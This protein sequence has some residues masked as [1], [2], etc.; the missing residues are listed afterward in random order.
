MG[1]HTRDEERG[2]EPVSA[3]YCGWRGKRASALCALLAA[4]L[5]HGD[6]CV[7]NWMRFA[8][9]E[10]IPSTVHVAARGPDGFVYLGGRD[11]LYRLEGGSLNAWYPEPGNQAA[12]P[13]G[14]V[15]ALH[16]DGEALWVGTGGGLLKFV[17]GS[18]RFEP[19]AHTVDEGASKRITALHQRGNRLFV[20]TAEGGSV[21]DVET[22]VFQAGMNTSSLEFT[23]AITRFV[24]FDGSVVAASS[25]GLL[26]IHPDGRTEAV[27]LSPGLPS[28]YRIADIALDTDGVLW[29][30]ATD[31]LYRVESLAASSAERL[32]REEQ[33]GLPEGV[34]VALGIDRQGNLWAG[35]REG[36]SRWA[37]GEAGFRHCRR[38]TSDSGEPALSVA[39]LDGTLGPS[40][41]L[42]SWGRGAFFAPPDRGTRR[43]VPGGEHQQGLPDQPIWSAIV[44]PDERLVLGTG[45]GVYRETG[46]LSDKFTA[47]APDQLGGLRVYALLRDNAG[48][49]WI[50]TSRGLFVAREDAVIAVTL[51]NPADTE[52]ATTPVF[53][54]QATGEEIAVATGHGLYLIDAE[55]HNLLHLFRARREVVVPSDTGLTDIDANRIWSVTVRGRSLYAASDTGAFHFDHPTRALVA[56]TS[57]WGDPARPRSGRIYAVVASADNRVFIATESGL[58]ETDPAFMSYRHVA[59]ANHVRFRAVMAARTS[60]DG[61]LWFAVAGNGMFRYRPAL[62]EW[63]HLSQIDGL[64]SN[65]VGQLGLHELADGRIAIA[66]G[67]SGMTLI[68]PARATSSEQTPFAL[69]AH[70]VTLG[71]DVATG[72]RVVIGP[73]RRD[74]SLHFAVPIL[75]GP[76]FQE[77]RYALWR[78]RLAPSEGRIRL[79]DELLLTQMQPGDYRF[80][81][82]LQSS[83]GRLSEPLVF[84]IS[85]RQYWWQS[86]YAHAGGFALGAAALLGVFAW[87]TRVIQQRYD[88]LHSE[89]QRIAQDLHDTFLQEML[90]ALMIGRSIDTTELQHAER[91]KTERV[92]EL[93]EDASR[94]ARSSVNE[95]VEHGAIVDLA[96]DLRECTLDSPFLKGATLHVSESGS[97]WRLPR[98]SCFFVYRAAREAINNA[99]KHARADSVR[100]TIDWKPWSMRLAVIDDGI[101]FDP[102]ANTDREGF[103]LHALRRL[104]RAAKAKVDIISAPGQGTRVEFALRRFPMF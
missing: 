69:S 44:T 39:T 4:G 35:S 7:P 80:E 79:G 26:Q 41:F 85:V 78:D 52:G 10:S 88:L 28:R 31:A 71:R 43:I 3:G 51:G 66:N 92:I 63:T 56:S 34:L 76:D 89:R 12:L 74:L 62:D 102:D 98:G 73:D 30:L 100:V 21:L 82:Q 38:P 15:L 86:G 37:R 13:A 87:R 29:A 18:N 75:I 5:A 53:A 96:T 57:D 45:R 103:G 77:V 20:G 54:L 50:G 11:G 59:G 95:L 19:V 17:P 8:D 72:D 68:D 25:A 36:I 101:G 27:P 22:G 104:A 9:T 99:F 47:L 16:N 49:L 94:S 97:S 91:R 42:G 70:T 6:A 40:L 64:L 58:I 61:S 46:A 83:S 24:E 81:A 65:S 90:G 84:D 67:G 93:L 1:D 32:G 2:G 23:P 60:R 14:H 55:T 33:P 48:Q